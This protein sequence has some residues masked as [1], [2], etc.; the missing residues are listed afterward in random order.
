MNTQNITNLTSDLLQSFTSLKTPQGVPNQA[1]NILCYKIMEGH[2]LRIPSK[3][4]RVNWALILFLGSGFILI[5]I[6]ILVRAKCI[7]LVLRERLRFNYFLSVQGDILS[8]IWRSDSLR[9]ISR[10]TSFL[11]TLYLWQ[12][13]A[14][15]WGITC[16]LSWLLLSNRNK[17]CHK[18]P[19]LH[20]TVTMATQWP[21]SP[22]QWPT[23]EA[24]E[25]ELW[26]KRKHP[27]PRQ[28]E[29]SGDGIG[30]KLSQDWSN[31]I[32]LPIWKL[33]AGLF[34]HWGVDKRSA[35]TFQ[36]LKI[37][38]NL[39]FASSFHSSSLL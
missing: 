34:W 11:V 8:T 2:L 15:T 32:L 25:F 38:R 18:M 3:P 37:L 19:I 12:A 24:S 21:P 1:N 9:F 31:L 28:W 17:I 27:R 4:M 30:G 35:G 5:W 7:F 39:K 6:E 29:N 33:I 10:T 14:V 16:L 20:K 22:R 13:R 26:P 23:G 36:S